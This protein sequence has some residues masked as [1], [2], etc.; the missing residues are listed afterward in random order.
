MANTVNVDVSEM[1]AFFQKMGGASADF[2]AEMSL[3]LDAVGN[4][5]LRIVQ[6]EII[7]RQVLDTRL[8]LASFEKG[9]DDNVWIKSDGD[10]TLEVGSSTNYAGY[11]NDGHWTNP[12]GVS[13][14]FVP[15]YWE[16]ERF[17][18][19]PGYTDEDGHAAGMVLK[20][21]WVEGAHY[22]DSALRILD[23]MFPDLMEAKIQQWKNKYFQ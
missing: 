22:F 6:D 1:R 16:G 8:L 15:G 18:Y 13:M 2:K 11:V 19:S 4:E 21:H 3:W 10:L 20:Q 7:R 9:A 17:I 12:K 5:F 14:R 23:A